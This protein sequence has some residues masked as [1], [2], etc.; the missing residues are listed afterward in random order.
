MEIQTVDRESSYLATVPGTEISYFCQFIQFV[1]NL[2]T[3]RITPPIG[4]KPKSARPAVYTSVV[5]AAVVH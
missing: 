2:A 3:E 5:Y 1:P 4:L